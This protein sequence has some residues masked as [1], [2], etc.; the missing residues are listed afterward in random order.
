ME[1]GLH[2]LMIQVSK[3]KQEEHER[4]K[5]AQPKHVSRG[6]Y[7]HQVGEMLLQRLIRE[8]EGRENNGVNRE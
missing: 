2:Y 3:R 7:R 4:K 1:M 5:E 8:Q 6:Y